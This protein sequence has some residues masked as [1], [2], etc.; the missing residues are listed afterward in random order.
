M[1]HHPGDRQVKILLIDGCVHGISLLMFTCDYFL[2]FW[3]LFCSWDGTFKFKVRTGIV[4]KSSIWLMLCNHNYSCFLR[5][6]LQ[7][8]PL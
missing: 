7:Y 3:D 8:I 1:Y 6:I 4:S 5:F 2:L